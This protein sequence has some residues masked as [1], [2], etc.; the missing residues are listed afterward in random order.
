MSASLV[1]SGTLGWK[2]TELVVVLMFICGV[3]LLQRRHIWLVFIPLAAA[4]Y[5][6]FNW[7]P[8]LSNHMNLYSVLAAALLISAGT[9]WIRRREWPD[10]LM[11]L[12]RESSIPLLTMIYVGAGF[13]KLNRS[14]LDVDHSCAGWIFD[15]LLNHYLA[16]DLDIPVPLI[17]GSIAA[18]FLF[19]LA[20]PLL[21][22]HHRTRGFA[23]CAFA[24]FHLFLS[25]AGFANF[26]GIAAILLIAGLIT[27][28]RITRP[29]VVQASLSLLATSSIAAALVTHYGF[30]SL[31]V[32]VGQANVMAGLAFG[33][34]LTACVVGLVLSTAPIKPMTH[35]R[36]RIRPARIA[37]VFAMLCWIAQPY[38]GLSNAGTLTM[39]SNLVT[40]AD[41][42]NHLLINTR[43][44]KLFDFEE[45][46]VYVD[47]ILSDFRLEGRDDL[48]FN[49]VPRHELQFRVR[50]WIDSGQGAI[51]AVVD[52]VR[53][54]DLCQSAYA[55]PPW[56]ARFVHMRAAP[57]GNEQQ[58][59]W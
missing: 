53:Y 45:D 7:F 3:A 2:H 14:Y 13:H 31:S 44:S 43:W 16:L 40:H 1:H 36:W 8:R 46:T 17:I 37:T 33:L 25:A 26:S 34:G 49:D 57:R 9:W 10:A 22:L 15:K 56:W 32:T 47:T 19:E 52:G 59:R 51:P 5:T 41:Y 38:L 54:Q 21:L 29:L 28:R 42:S 30:A 11:W 23:A 20:L 27:S 55:Y 39:F 6:G 58:C 35:Q 24:L 4:L 18:T 50:Q 12:L 48:G